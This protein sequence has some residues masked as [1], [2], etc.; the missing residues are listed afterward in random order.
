MDDEQAGLEIC[1]ARIVE[2]EVR[3]TLLG[4]RKVHA[5]PTHGTSR[6]FCVEQDLDGT[7]TLAPVTSEV[8]EYQQT[9][10]SHFFFVI[11]STMPHELQ[12]EFSSVARDHEGHPF[13]LI[14]NCSGSVKHIEEFIGEVVLKHASAQAPMTVQRAKVWMENTVRTRLQEQV[15]EQLA[16]FSF[17]ELRDREVLQSSWWEKKVNSWLTGSGIAITVGRACW[18]SPDAERAEKE[19]LNQIEMERHL[20]TS[21]KTHELELAVAQSDAAHRAEIAAIQAQKEMAEEDRKHEEEMARIRREIELE[22]MRDK[23]REV[24]TRHQADVLAAEADTARLNQQEDQARQIEQ[25]KKELLERNQREI[26][27]AKMEL[28]NQ[29]TRQLEASPGMVKQLEQDATRQAPPA[30]PGSPARTPPPVPQRTAPGQ[31]P[32]PV[33]SPDVI[34]RREDKKQAMAEARAKARAAEAQELM[35]QLSEVY[36]DAAKAEQASRAVGDSDTKSAFDYEVISGV[37]GKAAADSKSPPPLPPT[38]APDDA[39]LPVV[40]PTPGPPPVP[41]KQ[42]DDG[43]SV[44]EGLAD[45][46]QGVFGTLRDQSTKVTAKAKAM[47]K[48]ARDAAVTPQDIAP[49]PTPPPLPPAASDG[50]PNDGEERTDVSEEL[51]GRFRDVFGSQAQDRATPRPAV[52][53]RA[54]FD[55][56]DL[57]KKPDP[58][59]DDPADDMT[60]DSPDDVSPDQPT[61]VTPAP[62]ADPPADSQDDSE[63]EASP[64]TTGDESP[65]AP[66]TGLGAFAAQRRAAEKAA[67]QAPKKSKRPNKP[68]KRFSFEPKKRDE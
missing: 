6:L 25:M 10:D 21:E 63:A 51:A 20:E 42:K 55:P 57:A 12:L 5:P 52:S 36:D 31:T 47:A 9:A 53:G 68:T 13:D 3:R 48:A 45:T 28:A 56:K 1:L 39:L 27:Q 64:Q 50:A 15:A 2:P 38:S 29:L 18:E 19:R 11:A 17:E 32:P 58:P 43:K 8:V 30:L 33:P 24:K 16:R 59:I 46:L 23:L 67:G 22:D 44:S 65:Q 40:R 26:K 35:Q 49:P 66:K 4:K 62:P 41:L 14:L 7:S 61:D 60:D 54:T 34:R 37:F